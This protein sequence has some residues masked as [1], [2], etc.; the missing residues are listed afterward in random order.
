MARS[1]L[2]AF[3]WI[4]SLSLI[5]RTACARVQ[6]SGCISTTNDHSETGQMAVCCRNLTLGA[7]SSRSAPSVLFGALF[8]KFGLFLNTPLRSSGRA[9]RVFDVYLVLFARLNIMYQYNSFVRSTPVALPSQAI[10]QIYGLCTGFLNLRSE[11]L[12][13]YPN[14]SSY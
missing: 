1:S 14:T 2:I 8:K 6:F 7:L 11:V 4:S 3:S 5:R 13:V 10:I 12:Q 9:Q